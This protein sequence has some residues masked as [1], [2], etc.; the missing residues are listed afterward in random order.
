[1][2]GLSGFPEAARA[3]F[4]LT[5]VQLCIVRM[6][7][8]SA[9]FVSYKDLKQVCA[10]LN[11]VYTANTEAAGRDAL[12]EF[13]K[14]WDEKYPMIFQ[15]W[16]RH[17]DDLCEFFKYPPEIRKAVYTTNAVESMNYQLRKITKNRCSK[18]AK[19]IPTAFSRNDT[20]CKK[21]VEMIPFY[22]LEIAMIKHGKT[23]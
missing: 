22:F 5:R 12:E 13:G 21:P 2:D 10:G 11:A 15:S 23:R 3:V 18:P 4:P 14:K 16:R 19:M 9:K 7:R 20:F 17:W 8:N 6:I 1:M